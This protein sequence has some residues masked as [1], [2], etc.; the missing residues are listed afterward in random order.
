MSTI[1]KHSKYKNTGI[2]FELLVRQVTSDMMSNQD[3]KAVSIIK[4]YFK[5]TELSKEYGL[6]NT[7]INAPKLSEGKAESLINVVLDQSKKLQ[8]E[9]LNKEKYNLIREI[10]KHYDVENFF[11]AKVDN[12]KIS[13]ALYNLIESHNDNTYSDTKNIVVNKLTI[14]EHVTKELMDATKIEKKAVQEFM[15]EDRD[16][17]I[18]AYRILVEKFNNEYSDLSED[19]KLVLKEYINNITDTRQLKLFLN[20]K[21]QEVKAEIEN[22]IPKVE[23]K[24]T[25]IKLN[26]ILNLIKPIPEKKSIKEDNLVSLMQYYE[27]VKEIKTSIK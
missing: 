6:Y 21:I 27:L 22:L 7:V 17:R 19:Q 10:K 1:K 15:K 18:L 20:N 13:A 9:K 23:D 16:I 4:K 14:L 24:V 2:L 5:G 12:Y 3:S 26:E 11:K 25:T 8:R